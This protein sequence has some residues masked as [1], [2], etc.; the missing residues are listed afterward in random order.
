MFFHPTPDDL[1]RARVFNSGNYVRS[2]PA[3]AVATDNVV[4]G[5]VFTATRATDSFLCGVRVI[6]I[7]TR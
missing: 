3:A 5:V 2:D 4:V 6:I 7:I 1:A